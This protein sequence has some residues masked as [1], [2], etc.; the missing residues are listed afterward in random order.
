MGC[1]ST[2]EGTNNR[3]QNCDDDTSEYFQTRRAIGHAGGTRLEATQRQRSISLLRQQFVIQCQVCRITYVTNT[4]FCPECGQ[5]LLSREQIGTDPIEVEQIRWQ[6]EADDSQLKDME[7]PLARPVTIYLRI[8]QDEKVRILEISLVKPIR[9]GRS[10]PMEDIFPEVDLTDDG[11][12]EHGV[13]REH[14]CIF[15]RDN[16]VEVEDMGSTNGT[17]LNGERLAPYI[18]RSMKDGDQIQMGK[19]LIEVSF[20]T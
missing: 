12:K 9:L 2:S 16:A 18:S 6:G 11:G 5:Y 20:E 4:I 17:L 1:L 7:M 13:S 19:L 8:G 14:A 15:Q 3:R 10:D